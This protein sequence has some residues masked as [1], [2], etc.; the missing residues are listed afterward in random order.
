[1]IRAGAEHDS[2]VDRDIERSIAHLRAL[3]DVPAEGRDAAAS[4][5]AGED[6]GFEPFPSLRDLGTVS[7]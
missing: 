7:V 3:H 6:V 4:E 2:V 5:R 1:M